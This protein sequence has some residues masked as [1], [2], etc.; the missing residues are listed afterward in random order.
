MSSQDTSGRA[1]SKKTLSAGEIAGNTIALWGAVALASVALWPIYED[2]ALIVLVGVCLIS[3]SG[4][5]ILAARLRLNFAL[6]LLISIGTFFAI[7]VPLA[8]PSE[9]IG[10]FLPSLEGLRQLVFAVPLGWK[11]LLT[12]TLPVGTYQALLV[13]AL[14]LVFATTVISLTIALRSRW[15]NVAALGPVVLYLVATALG[16]PEDAW[17]VTA[18]LALIAVTL[19]WL[20]ARR[21][22]ARNEAIRK[23][24][25]AQG[26]D[27]SVVSVPRNH[28]LVGARQ[29]VSAIVIFAVAGGAGVAAVSALP[30]TETKLVLRSSIE[31][32][33]DPRDY[34][35]PLAGFRSY[36]VDPTS[37]DVLLTFTGLDVGDK[38]RVA[39]LDTYNGIVY[40]VGAASESTASG[41]FT[42]VPFSFDQSNFVGRAAT[43]EVS[44][45]SWDSVWLP[46]VGQLSE[47]NFEGSRASA[48]RDSFYYNNTTGTAAVIDGVSDGDTY[49]VMSVIAEQPSAAELSSLTPGSEILPSPTIPEELERVLT[50]YTAG[51]TEPGDKLVRLLGGLAAEGYISHGISE[52]EP[53]SRS[54]HSADRITQLLTDQL[55]IGDAEQY[56][57]T[58]AI[59]ARQVGFP[60]RIVF[61]FAPE[62]RAGEPTRVRGNSVS[63]WI[64][65][66]TEEYG[67]VQIDPTPAERPI[68]E[69]EPEQPTV[70]SRPQP[71]IPPPAEE[72]NNAVAVTQLENTQDNPEQL[73]PWLAT[74]LA[75]A[76]VAAWIALVAGILASPFL[77]IVATKL[78][79]RRSRRNADTA[80]EQ[81]RGGWQ[82]YYDAVLDH[83]VPVPK[84]STRREVATVVG[85]A[86]S[87]VL[88]AVTDRAVFAPHDVSSSDAEKVWRAVSELRAG[89]DV[90]RTR[91]QKFTARVSMR[92]LGKRGF[93]RIDKHE[94]K[95]SEM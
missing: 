40:S 75:A 87:T 29:V 33:F 48:L 42:R 65:V 86:R 19:L 68:P 91:W 55:M 88:A 12:I 4:I 83:G 60:S 92:S 10:G 9:S 50:R 25:R 59:M 5:A 32:P 14:I 47:V 56:A 13:P 69:A 28:R 44:V 46:T 35:S 58:A 27:Y 51:S 54:G 18:T 21:W 66:N 76:T 15:G 62:I 31:Q 77:A 24:V 3:A 72:P 93:M 11:Q 49:T 71:V 80:L 1:A 84:H 52:A 43:I 39:T 70:V 7:G 90:G 45:G 95:S 30:P 26:Q 22:R 79:R 67:W 74:L 57:V 6:T 82:E 94:E 36:F 61:G 37:T 81:M 63:A 89:L 34:V 17:P 41:S 85:G 23:L 2:A 38:I 8:V 73:E 16:P 78:R 64:E 20:M 53:P